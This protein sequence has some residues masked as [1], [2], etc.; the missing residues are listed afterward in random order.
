MLGSQAIAFEMQAP[1][2]FAQVQLSMQARRQLF[3]IFKESIHN[4]ARHSGGTAVVA[5]LTLAGQ[6]V[7]LRVEDDGRGLSG[8]G[9]ASQS[10]GS[11]RLAIGLMSAVRCRNH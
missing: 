4:A 5:E 1:E 9:G 3:L 7:T 8:N 6:E 2:K 10:G 11:S